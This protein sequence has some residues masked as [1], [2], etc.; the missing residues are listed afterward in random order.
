VATASFGQTTASTKNTK[1]TKSTPKKSGKI[2]KASVPKAVTETY[3]IEY[4]SGL[5]DRWYGYPG[6]VNDEE[7]YDYNPYLFTDQYPEN[8][9]VEFTESETPVKA[10]Y[11][12]AGKKIATHRRLKTDVT[13]E[14]SNAINRSAYKTWKVKQEKE[15]IIKEDDKTRI[16]YKVIVENGAEKH[17]LFFLP[18]GKLVK[19]KKLKS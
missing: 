13:K 10:V 5:N 4:P 2:E 14:I 16:I 7:W 1:S 15:E 18:D 6:F 9:I 3:I 12:K 17:A 19:D 11:T 8:Y